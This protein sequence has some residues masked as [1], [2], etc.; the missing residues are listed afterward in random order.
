MIPPMHKQILWLDLCVGK[1]Q[2]FG[3]R[4]CEEF[5]DDQESKRPRAHRPD[6]E[7]L[8]ALRSLRA[9]SRNRRRH[10]S[11][12]VVSKPMRAA[13]KFLRRLSVVCPKGVG[14]ADD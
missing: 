8:P 1:A 11:P 10:T 3:P 14:E 2:R 6:Q 4:F 12:L 7:R 9:A 5:P 13:P